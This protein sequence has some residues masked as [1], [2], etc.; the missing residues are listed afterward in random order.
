MQGFFLFFS[1]SAHT[2]PK[3]R[4]I[5]GCAANTD[6]K[7]GGTGNGRCFQSEPPVAREGRSGLP[8]AAGGDLPEVPPTLP[9]GD[10]AM[11]LISPPSRYTI[12]SALDAC[13]PQIEAAFRISPTHM[14]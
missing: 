8:G 3:G 1:H 7:T 5:P 10:A 9:R 12:L 11:R 13:A 2:A 4:R 14:P 6:A